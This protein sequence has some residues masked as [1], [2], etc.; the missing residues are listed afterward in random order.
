MKRLNTNRQL[1]LSI[2]MADVNGL[3]L[4]NDSL[5]HEKRS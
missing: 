1:L 3:K 4:I 2:I 5:G